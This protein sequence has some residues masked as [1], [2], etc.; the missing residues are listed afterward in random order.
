MYSCECPWFGW[1]P[2]ATKICT[3]SW[4]LLVIAHLLLFFFV[5]SPYKTASS[6]RSAKKF[7]GSSQSNGFNGNQLWA[8]DDSFTNISN[9]QLFNEF[10]DIHKHC[11]N[12]ECCPVSL[13]IVG[14]LWLQCC[15][16]LNC[17][18]FHNFCMI[19]LL[20]CSM[21]SSKLFFVF[22]VVVVFLLAR[23]C[24]LI[25]LSGRLKSHNSQRSLFE[26][27]LKMPLPLFLSLSLVRICLLITLM[28]FL[29][30]HKRPGS[31]SSVVKC[32]IE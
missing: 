31:L 27:V 32:L 7:F 16:V 28:I 4:L 21:V 30:C 20:R 19:A 24:F 6:H 23:S 14:S 12:C 5:V 10:E 3:R 8:A 11:K 9:P 1:W 17:Q 15:E 18:K 25:T 29:K 2:S 26:G 13:F 22:L